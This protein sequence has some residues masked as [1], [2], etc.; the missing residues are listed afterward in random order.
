MAI[1]KKQF[2][3]MSELCASQ[4]QSAFDNLIETLKIAFEFG[5]FR[6]VIAAAEAFTSDA[7]RHT[8]SSHECPKAFSNPEGDAWKM[9]L[10][11][12]SSD[13]NLLMLKKRIL[14]D[15]KARLREESRHTPAEKGRI[16]KQQTEQV[17][18]KKSKRV[19][20]V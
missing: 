14:I 20:K 11:T 8:L 6:K 12:A 7:F 4:E 2:A 9:H 18:T 5:G 16:A 1:T 19:A 17:T 15:T 10:L 13:T 3:G